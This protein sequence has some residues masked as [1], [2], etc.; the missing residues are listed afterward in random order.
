MQRAAR[1]LIGITAI[2]FAVGMAPGAVATPATPDIVPSGPDAGTMSAGSGGR[3]GDF[4]DDSA[5]DILARNAANG[6]LRVYPHSGEYQGTS[7]FQAAQM[8]LGDS[9]TFRWIGQGDFNGDGFADVAGITRVDGR[10]LIALN[11][12]GL[13]GTDT[14]AAGYT[15]SY[16]WNSTDLV[17]TGDIDGDGNDDIAAR[18]KGTNS[19]YAYINDRNTERPNFGAPQLLTQT[20][21]GVI[22]Q[23][24]ADITGDGTP[25]LLS[26]RSNGELHMR[27][28][29]TNPPQGQSY[30]IGTGY[31]VNTALLVNDVNLDDKPDLLGRTRNGTLRAYLHGGEWDTAN[32]EAVLGRPEAISY[33]W[34]TN[35]VIS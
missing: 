22:D 8:I 13:N 30:L 3:S 29:R 1:G 2:A 27:D 24:L 4:N 7:T 19:T 16:G 23:Q 12:G 11:N 14:L 32:P 34:N 28:Y 35:D 31:D 20:G 26:L 25:D 33:G 5:D 6:Q 21:G 9:R 18:R 15:S 10:L 17:F